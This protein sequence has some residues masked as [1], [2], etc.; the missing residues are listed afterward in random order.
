MHQQTQPSSMLQNVNFASNTISKPNNPHIPQPQRHSTV[1]I[2]NFSLD[3]SPISKQNIA[4][5]NQNQQQK[6]TT[7]NF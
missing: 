3:V 6:T 2:P 5:T 4:A 1:P 7:P